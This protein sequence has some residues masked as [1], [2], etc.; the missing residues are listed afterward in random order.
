VKR[1]RKK[2]TTGKDVAADIKLDGQHNEP[3]PRHCRREEDERVPDLRIEPIE[4]R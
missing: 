3:E 4:R 1:K 2:L